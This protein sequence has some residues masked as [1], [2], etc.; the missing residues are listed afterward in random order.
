[1]EKSY[2][3]PAL[4]CN[5]A[6]LP[7]EHPNQQPIELVLIEVYSRSSWPEF[8]EEVA[9]FWRPETRWRRIFRAPLFRRLDTGTINKVVG[10]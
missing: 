9:E 7:Q 5:P 1:M 2:G 4:S 10:V 6:D 3:A 8:G